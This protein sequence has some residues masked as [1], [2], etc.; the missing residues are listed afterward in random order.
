MI[1][2]RTSIKLLLFTILAIYVC[3]HTYSHKHLS[4]RNALDTDDELLIQKKRDDG[5]KIAQLNFLQKKKKTT[6]NSKVAVSFTLWKTH[7]IRLCRFVYVVCLCMSSLTNHSN[8]IHYEW[9]IKW[10]T[11]ATVDVR[12]RQAWNVRCIAN[13]KLKSKCS[14]ILGMRYIVLCTLGLRA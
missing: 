10:K 2:S 6:T 11:T 13:I 12:R 1:W 7:V 3:I 9:N 5:K 8:K 14:I 4:I